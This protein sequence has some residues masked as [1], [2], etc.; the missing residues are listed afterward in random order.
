MAHDTAPDLAQIQLART[1]FLDCVIRTEVPGTF[2]I[3]QITGYAD[4]E[5]VIRTFCDLELREVGFDVQIRT[6]ALNQAGQPLPATGYFRLHFVFQVR[7]LPDLLFVNPD[8]PEAGET[9]NLPLTA[10]LMG[11]AYSTARGMIVSKV[12]DTVLNGFALPLRAVQRLL[13]DTNQV[14][15]NQLNE[16]ALAAPVRAKSGRAAKARKAH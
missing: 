13:D 15:R 7:N 16:P 10:S 5:V 11:A 12:S 8:R 2:D 6:T 3:T 14:L 4:P 9:P 1:A